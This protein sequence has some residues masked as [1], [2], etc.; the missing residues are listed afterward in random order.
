VGPEEAIHPREEEILPRDEDKLP[1]EE[2][3]LGKYQAI[4]PAR[5]ENDPHAQGPAHAEVRR[6]RRGSS[7]ALIQTDAPRPQSRTPLG[8][9]TTEEVNRREQ[10]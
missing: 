5:E 2:E 1:S 4:L 3:M 9:G 6:T 7:E 8:Q 10:R